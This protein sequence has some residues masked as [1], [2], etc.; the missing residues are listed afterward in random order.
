MTCRACS[1]AQP[2]PTLC[3]PRDCSPQAPLSMGL[4]RQEHWSGLLCPPPGD[5]PDPGTEPV[6]LTSPALAGEFFTTRVT[7]EAHLNHMPPIK[8]RTE[9]SSWK[10]LNIT[11]V[12]AS[13]R[14]SWEPSYPN[15]FHNRSL[16]LIWIAF[17]L[18]SCLLWNGFS[19][20]KNWELGST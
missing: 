7:W 4:S 15:I 11:G 8:Y 13:F 16:S 9:E 14:A 5:L 3:D 12:S 2:C 18:I 19:Y 20:T 6:S 17:P 1:G 10:W